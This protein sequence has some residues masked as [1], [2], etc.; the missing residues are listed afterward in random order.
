[1]GARRP[2]AIVV[3]V[4]LAVVAFV[5][6]A[7]A[8][9]SRP[10]P[11]AVEGTGG[12]HLDFRRDGAPLRLPST[13]EPPPVDDTVD[14]GSTAGD[15]VG[16]LLQ[17]LAALVVVAIVVAVL[18]AVLRGIQRLPPRERRLPVA[19]PPGVPSGAEM[20][21]AVDEGIAALA[22]G[23]I[24]DV[25]VACWVRL[26]AAADAGG[27]G[28]RPSETAS[29]LTVRVLEQFDAPRALPSAC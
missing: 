19:A 1:M 20:A 7:V 13:A 4:G 3:A 28:R 15:V 12:W 27:V 9:S 8:T 29:E 25:I 6:V 5:A 14:D 18:R 21:E 16:V 10:V 11:L 22:D 24:D 17:A 2:L 26:E 23:P